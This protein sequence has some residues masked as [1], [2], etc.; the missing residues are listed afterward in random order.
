MQHFANIEA[1]LDLILDSMSLSRPKPLPPRKR[2]T[3]SWAIVD[4]T[5]KTKKKHIIIPPGSDA[6]L[7]DV[8][9]AS[10]QDDNFAAYP[11]SDNN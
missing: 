10:Y 2:K 3:R 1:K 5:A 7:D 9:N 6:D 8:S 4:E 11:R